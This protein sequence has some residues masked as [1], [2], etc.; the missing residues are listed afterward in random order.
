MTSEDAITLPSNFWP[1]YEVIGRG[2]ERDST[3]YNELIVKT[4]GTVYCRAD[5]TT[6]EVVMIT[7][8]VNEF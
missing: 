8:L 5:D 2:N 4:D 1:P 6:T 7:Y 3:N